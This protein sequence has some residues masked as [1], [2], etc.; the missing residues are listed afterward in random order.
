MDYVLPALA[1]FVA[2]SSILLSPKAQTERTNY[3]P[4]T[5]VHQKCRDLLLARRRKVAGSGGAEKL[6]RKDFHRQGK[7]LGIIC[8]QDYNFNSPSVG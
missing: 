8:K 4:A 6:F 5:L 3:E 7:E 1:G 2:I